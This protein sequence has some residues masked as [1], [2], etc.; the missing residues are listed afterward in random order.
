MKRIDRR[1]QTKPPG[2]VSNKE[3]PDPNSDRAREQ[4]RSIS[5]DV[6]VRGEIS[7]E[8]TPQESL[9]RSVEN[10]KN[11]IRES[12]KRHLE[13]ATL[14]VIGIYAALTAA[15]T[16]LT[17]QLVAS[18]QLISR[19]YVG[20]KTV[21]VTHQSRDAD[22]NVTSTRHRTRESDHLTVAVEI[23]NFGPV[24]AEDYTDHWQMIVGDK[25]LPPAPGG[26]PDKPRIIFPTEDIGLVG[27]IEDIPS[28]PQYTDVVEG[29]KPLKLKISWRYKGP[30]GE[31]VC[32]T[33]KQYDRF[34]DSFFDLGDTCK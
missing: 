33:N 12:K 9:A 30:D 15:Q 22:R 26:L 3:H 8:A 5:G 32:Q 6:H 4:K 2:V 28:D 18:Q 16:Y 17:R 1:D 20:I 7:V 19:P 10:Q 11:D 34:S 13:I 23:T 25:I 21:E 14:V 24:P 27:A 31:H 29:I